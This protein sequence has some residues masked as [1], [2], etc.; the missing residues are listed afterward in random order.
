MGKMEQKAHG[1]TICS[2]IFKMAARVPFPVVPARDWWLPAL[3]FLIARSSYVWVARVF[4][5]SKKE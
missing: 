5:F 1:L 2:N 3:H 4:W